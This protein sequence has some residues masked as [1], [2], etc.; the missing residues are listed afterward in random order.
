MAFVDYYQ[1]LGIQ[2]TA[3]EKDIK[4]AYR[5]LARKYHPDVNPNDQ[6]A[7]KKFQEL[8]EAN[9]VLSDPEKRKNMTSMER[10][11]NMGKNMK[12]RGKHVPLRLIMAEVMRPVAAIIFL[13]FL[14]RCLV[15]IRDL[16]A[17]AALADK[18]NSEV[19]ITRQKC[20]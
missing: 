6:E 12:K 7:Q 19:R 16:E 5:K 11:G 8:N 14:N 17:A 9:E 1:I 3:S 13:I 4:A 2:K 15:E 20:I 10:T 18:P